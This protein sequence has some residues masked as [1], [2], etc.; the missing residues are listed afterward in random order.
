MKFPWRSKSRQQQL[1]EE[2]RSHLEMATQDR[3]NRG[4]S[5]DEATRAAHREFGN[6]PLIETVTRDQ[7]SWTWLYNLAQEFHYAART[8]R[9]NPAFATIAVLTLA[10]GI[11]ANTAIFSVVHGVLLRPLPFANVSTLLDVSARSTLF[12]FENLSISLPDIADVRASASSFATLTPYTSATKELAGDGKPARLEGADINE[13]FFPTLGI[14]PLLGRTFT[15]TDMQPGSRAVVISHALWRERF[16]ADS[17]VIGKSLFVDDQPKTIIGVMPPLSHTGFATDDQLW[18]PLVPSDDQRNLRQSRDFSVLARLQPNATPQQAQQELDT[19]TARLAAAYPDTNKGWTMHA[20]PITKFLLGDARTPLLILFCAVGFVLLI[21]CANVSNLFL[22]RGWS[23]RREFAIRSALGASRGALLRQLL[24]ESLLVALAGGACAFLVA[25]WAMQALRSL[26]PP[27]TPRIQEIGINAQVAVFTVTAALVAAI[28]SGLAPALLGSRTDVNTAIKEGS[29]GASA[30]AVHNSLRRLLAAGEV[31]V[32]AILLIGAALA[33]Q[34]FAR[35]LHAELGFRPEHIVTMRIEFPEF[36]FEKP[37]QGI[38]FVNQVLENS[39]SV[40]GVQAASAGLIFPLGDFIAETT[41]RTEKTASDPRLGEQMAVHNQIAP[42]FFRTFGI[43]LLAGRDF[44]G[45]DAKDRPPVF[46]INEVLAR[47]YFG[48]VD[49][50]GKRLSTRKVKGQI[51][52]GQIVGVVGNVREARPAA[53]PKVEIY[54]PFS[55]ARM[56]TGI[57]L[58]VRTHADPL[59]IV[60]VIQDRVWSLDKNRPISMIKTVD[61]QIVE[62]FAAPRSQS[63]L[64]SIFSGLGF[65]LALVGVYGVISYIVSQQTREIGIR[66]AL[67]AAPENILRAIITDGLK[68]TLAGV[69]IG[70]GASFGLTRF[71]RTLLFELSP[72]D[73]LTFATVAI[74]LTLVAIAACYIPARRAMTVDPMIALRHE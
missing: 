39:R 21:A 20:T 53:E 27:E 24:V 46:V 29:A 1:N 23:R 14:T 56:A 8:L 74:A 19:I 51:V 11:G 47:K 32:A 70:L 68:L 30:A 71:L 48:S 58:A 25:A 9:K 62:D 63:L 41:F 18:S 3:L 38:A 65:V 50:V 59:A 15:S 33:V 69:T 26:L 35:L 57:F 55:Q 73:P 43:P 52:W 67:G 17:N 12:D 54:E 34:S 61:Q 72:T 36:R 6:L 37:E 13:D 60:P 49:V 7:W 66:M 4:I 31:A 10:L 22:S 44:N 2:L 40:P 45:G 64:L 5:P 16:G 28:L 42:D